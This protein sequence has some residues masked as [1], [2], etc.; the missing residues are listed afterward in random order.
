VQSLT[1]IRLHL[2]IMSRPLPSVDLA[3]LL[4]S[5]GS[6]LA[7]LPFAALGRSGVAHARWQPEHYRLCW[8]YWY[9]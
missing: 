7:G 6:L 1:R 8:R 2:P 5:A 9:P 3:L 4:V